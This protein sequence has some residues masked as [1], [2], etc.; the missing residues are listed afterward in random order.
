[1]RKPSHLEENQWHENYHP[2]SRSSFTLESDFINTGQAANLD[3]AGHQRVTFMKN[4]PVII[5]ASVVM[6]HD[7]VIR[8][9]R[10]ETCFHFTEADHR[11]QHH[12]QIIPVSHIILTGQY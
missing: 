2:P 9:I 4:M 3:T 6:S 11:G 5:E 10:K 8:Q 12:P 7:S 1:M